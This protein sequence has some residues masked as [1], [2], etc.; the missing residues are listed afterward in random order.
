MQPQA[1]EGPLLG[2]QKRELDSAIES[3][4]EKERARA[5]EY[6]CEGV[7]CVWGGG[8]AGGRGGKERA[9]ERAKNSRE[10][11]NRER[12]RAPFPTLLM[13]PVCSRKRSEKQIKNR[14]R[15][16]CVP[17]LWMAQVCSQPAETRSH[18]FG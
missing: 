2:L 1:G 18:E 10:T 12:V 17:P 11:R 14:K 3:H 15:R 9:S 5:S 16:E 7:L 4:R 6:M 8:G 13:A